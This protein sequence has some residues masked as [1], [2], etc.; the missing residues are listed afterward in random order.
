MSERRWVAVEIPLHF[1][2]EIFTTGYRFDSRVYV[3]DGLP[4]GAKFV[5]ACYDAR[6]IPPD[7]L[8]VFEHES[9]DVVKEGTEIPRKIIILYRESTR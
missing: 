1:L 3:K 6:N 9:F 4:E 7:A 5:M 8:Y 2:Q